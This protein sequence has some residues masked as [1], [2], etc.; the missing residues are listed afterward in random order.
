MKTSAFLSLSVIVSFLIISEACNKKECVVQ[1][2]KYRMVRIVDCECRCFRD[3]VDVGNLFC[4]DPGMYVALIPRMYDLDTFALNFSYNP[5]LWPDVPIGHMEMLR[6]RTGLDPTNAFGHNPE[7]SYVLNSDGS[8][9]IVLDYLPAPDNTFPVFNVPPNQFDGWYKL[10]L[11]G[12]LP[13]GIDSDTLYATVHYL[14]LIDDL[15]D[16]IREPISFTMFKAR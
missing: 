9:N 4:V 1:C 14:N 8:I 15:F 2:P 6:P 11:E 7:T 10:K 5:V 16:P 12:F 13:N 3:V